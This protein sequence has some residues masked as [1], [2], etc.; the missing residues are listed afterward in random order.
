M[1]RKPLI[2]AE[3]PS[4]ARA[5]AE[6][7]GG[8]RRRSGYLES[9]AY[10]LTWAV[11]HLVEL[12]EPEAYDP[13][14]RRWSLDN[15]PILPATFRLRVVEATRAQ[16]EVIRGLMARATALINAC[17][18]GREGE[19]IFRYILEAAGAPPVPVYRLWISSL[20]PE[21]VRKGFQ[22][23]RPAAEYDRLYLS[24]LC[25]ARGDWL[26]GMNASRAFT[27]RFGELFSV[28]RV[29]TPTLAL[30]VRREREIR[31]F[32]PEPYW[33]VHA[34][35]RTA[36]GEEYTGRWHGDGGDRLPTAE[37][38][39]AVRQRV[40]AA[41]QGQVVAVED[42]EEAVRP[43]QLYDLN[44]LQ[45][46]ANRRY[47]LT[48]A[49]TLAAAQALYEKKLITYP[50]TDSRYLTRDVA[51]QAERVLRALAALPQYREAA[52]GAN[53]RR[54]WSGRIVQE[55]K[56]TDHHAIVPTG[57]PVP[58]LSGNEA[59]VFDLVARR[60]LAN[61]YPD[62]RFRQVEV[63]TAVGEDRFRSRGRVR[64]E[65]GWQAVDPPAGE[66][67]AGGGRGRRRRGAVGAAGA[68]GP[69]G[70][71]G[72]G[73]AA[74]DTGATGAEQ[75]PGV[76]DTGPGGEEGDLPL[77]PPLAAGDLVAV[78]T[79]E[80]VRKETQPPRRYTEAALLSAMENA[81]QELED[82]ALKEAMAGRGLG[83]PA[84]RAAIIERLKEVG[85]IATRGKVLV[86]TPKGERLV[87]LV[88]RVGVPVLLSAELTG[89]WEKQIADI[90][91]GAADP[92]QVLAGMRDLAVQV[93][94]KVRAAALPPGEGT[95]GGGGN[96][97]A[98]AGGPHTAGSAGSQGRRAARARRGQSRAAA[99]VAIAKGQVPPSPGEL[100]AAPG[101]VVGRCP[102]CGQP[103]QW[104]GGDWRCAGSGCPLRIPGTLCGRAIGPEVAGQLLREGRTQRLEGFVSRAGNPFAAYLVL[105][106]GRVEFAFDPPSRG[107]RRPR[108]GGGKTGGSG[109]L[110]PGSGA[111]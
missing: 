8:F 1:D 68:G 63:E 103:V 26:V 71:A 109:R 18:A 50:R 96:G 9:D 69:D 21:A 111:S 45:R 3:K 13:R 78:A 59:R 104:Q 93:V 77:L 16:F 12:V 88:D 48:A 65:A 2:I 106:A 58:P 44:S 61:L 15:L 92:D 55:A 40:L 39:E 38:A 6:G 31:A 20:T 85:Y 27:C 41:G 33:E 47:G 99:A 89:E 36:G 83:T 107:G 51:A 75:D 102:L 79:A 25:R 82:E 86:P 4:A 66:G 29:Q 108:S 62:A 97:A 23:L 46:E 76:P 11:G 53:P 24:A 52:A 30:L 91:A 17:D 67:S 42:R 34:R 32:K 94:E 72:G 37:A 98:G 81:G 87:D 28:G 95:P 43:P 90:Q 7:L 80:V 5:I 22:N 74:P 35:F 57:L 14:W 54:I 49:A 10:L 19:L 64:V 105:N 60:F 100:P 101:V 73:G 56:V 70:A 110:T 84:T